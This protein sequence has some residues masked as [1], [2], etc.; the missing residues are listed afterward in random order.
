[1][2][3][4]Q[5]REYF[6]ISRVLAD[7]ADATVYFVRAVVRNARTN[8]VI[9]TLNLVS[10]GNGAWAY[11]WQV[12][13]DPSGQGI[14]ISIT[15][16]V[17]TDSGYTTLSDAYVQENQTYQ[18][19]DRMKWVAAM[20]QQISAIGMGPDIDYKKIGAVVAKAITKGLEPLK[21]AVDDIA[22][23]VDAIELPEA[24]ETDLGPVLEGLASLAIALEPLGKLQNADLSNITA[25]IND[26]REKVA[27]IKMPEQK[28]TDLSPVLDAIKNKPVTEIDHDKI[29][30]ALMP[31]LTD[32]LKEIV[33]PEFMD[34]FVK[35]GM[36]S[37][38]LTDILGRRDAK[39]TKPGPYKREG[40]R[41]IRT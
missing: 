30:T 40:N 5:P 1:M 26:A 17:Y 18:I 27:A 29:I 16:R 9:D 34:N 22:E 35:Q 11:S 2:L 33:T 36:S 21:T 20:A 19:Y 14:F 23:D 12:P 13:A 37:S 28:E 24:K 3:S 38:M 10:L 25:L 31:A 41:Y 39:P 8:A 7:P 15:T 6:P 4:L 32:R